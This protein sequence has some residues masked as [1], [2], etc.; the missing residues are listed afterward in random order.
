MKINL[1]GIDAIIFDLGGVILNIDYD[2]T[3]EAFRELGGE[4]FDQLYTQAHQNHI[5]DNFEIGKSSPDDFI[6]YMLDFLPD[7][8]D[9]NLI[10]YAWNLMLM[11]LPKSRVEFLIRLGKEKRIFLFSNT[12]AIHFKEVLEILKTEFGTEKLFDELFEKAYFSHLA[13]KR[14]PNSDAFQLV[15]SENNL[16]PAKTLF[17]DDSIQHIEGANKVGLQTYHLV[18]EDITDIFT[19]DQN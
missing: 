2:L 3:I 13:G 12:N 1:N 11:D 9:A 8:Y 18:D 10:V 14:K 7:V 6:N 17:I 4:N 19:F 15:I 16:D 5:I